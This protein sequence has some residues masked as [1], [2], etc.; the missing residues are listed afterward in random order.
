MKAVA[1][2]CAQLVFFP[3]IC[4]AFL[5][6]IPDQLVPIF[7]EWASPSSPSRRFSRLRFLFSLEFSF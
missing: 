6:I 4:V 3:G 2:A 5:D 7:S 1:L